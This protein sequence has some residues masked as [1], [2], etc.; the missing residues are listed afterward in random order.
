MYQLFICTALQQIIIYFITLSYDSSYAIF[1]CSFQLHFFSCQKEHK[2][3]IS[4]KQMEEQSSVVL[5][6]VRA[7]AA[8][9]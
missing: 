7:F 6:V 2:A 5:N 8:Q 9:K 4:N 3:V 1:A